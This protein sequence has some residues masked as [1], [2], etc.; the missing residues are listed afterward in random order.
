MVK[1]TNFFFV[2]N[3]FFFE[4]LSVSV[5]EKKRENKYFYD[6]KWSLSLFSL[7][8]KSEVVSV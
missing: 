1:S 2:R 5:G 4:S 6:M 3:Y 8:E 7:D